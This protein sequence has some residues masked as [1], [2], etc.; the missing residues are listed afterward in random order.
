MKCPF[1]GKPGA[2]SGK[3]CPM[4]GKMVKAPGR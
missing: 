3:K 1:C 2:T 4:C